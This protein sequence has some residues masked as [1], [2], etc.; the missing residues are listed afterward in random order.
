MVGFLIPGCLFLVLFYPPI[1]SIVIMLPYSGMH[2]RESFLHKNRIVF[3]IPGGLH[4]RQQDW[5]P[6]VIAFTDDHGFSWYIEEEASFTVLYNFGHFSY[7]KGRSVY[8]D[9]KSP[10]YNS[11]F[12]GYAVKLQ[13][14][15]LFGFFVDGSIHLEELSKVPRFDQ[16]HLVLPSLGCPPPLRVFE[17]HAVSIVEHVPYMGLEDWVRIDSDIIT[18]SPLHTPSRAQMGY[19][20]FGRP[21]RDRGMETEDFPI[22]E[23][24]GR[25]YVR[26]FEEYGATFVLYVMAPSWAMV[27]ACDRDFLS[28]SVIR[29][30]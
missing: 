15:R 6:F 20:Q 27:D 29:Q 17:D 16:M 28:Q 8:Y 18:N 24:K 10:F 22:V 11:F 25:A 21:P 1:R 13:D 26:Y 2:Y 4:T 7:T 12:G 30:R 14:S 5:Y 23:M 9:T 19:L 3:D